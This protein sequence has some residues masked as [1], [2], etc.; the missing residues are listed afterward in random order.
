MS[1]PTTASTSSQDQKILWE[2]KTDAAHAVKILTDT[3][4]YYLNKKGSYVVTREGIFLRNTNAKE[5]VFCDLKLF[6]ENF[7]EY[8]FNSPRDICFAVNLNT[9]YN[10][11]LKKIRKKDSITIQILED[12]QKMYLKVTNE[13]PDNKGNT[14]SG[15]ILIVESRHVPVEPPTGYTQPITIR[16]KTFQQSCRAITRP[17]N[18]EIEITCYNDRTLRFFTGKDGCVENEA[19]FGPVRNDDKKLQSETFRASCLA[20]HIVRPAK[21]A[22]LSD[23]IKIFVQKGLP[24]YYKINVGSLGELGI[25][26]KTIDQITAEKDTADDE[27]DGG[28]D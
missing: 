16:A 23:I 24:V 9:F 6:A 19:T 7:Q 13:S 12:A 17:S 15:K 3:L 22:G 11:M 25:Y 18:K 10:D 21:L 2:A 28:D 5:E 27:D 26:I 4:N 20:A 1:S 14:Y 8:I